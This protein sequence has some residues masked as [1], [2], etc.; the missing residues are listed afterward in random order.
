MARRTPTLGR[1]LR[2][3]REGRGLSARYAAGMAGLSPSALTSIERGERYP[4]LET[5]EALCG[6]L[7]VTVIVGPRETFLEPLP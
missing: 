7:R 1:E 3:L 2:A 4:S 5:L 6:V